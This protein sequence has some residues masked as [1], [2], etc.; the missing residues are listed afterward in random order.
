MNKVRITSGIYFTFCL[1]IIGVISCTKEPFGKREKQGELVLPATSYAYFDKHGINN[2]LATLGRVLFYD[3]QLSANNAVS[4]GSCHKQE[5]AFANNVRFDKG[6]NG[7]ELNRN[8]P[9]IQGINGFFSNS[10]DSSAGMPTLQNQNQVLLFWD[11]RQNNVAD[12]VLNPV[13]NHNEM[14]LPDFE[15]LVKKLS[16][17]SYYP[18]LFQKSFG[19][20]KIT[21]ERIAFALEGFI[22]CMNSNGNSNGNDSLNE[23]EEQGKLLFHNKYNCAQCHDRSGSKFGSNPG[24]YGGGS[25]PSEMFNIGLDEVYKDNGLGK[26]TGKPGDKGLFKVPTL[27]N[28]SVTAPYMHDGRFANLGEVLD[29]YSHGIKNNIN[30]S[31]KFLNTD[32]TPTKLNITPVEK[33]AIIAFLNTL[34]NEDFLVNP[35]YANPFKKK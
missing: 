34:K 16:E 10:F 35:M 28:I 11:G 9:S 3:Q 29:H 7:L 26:I 21:K 22:S 23:L 14:N 1:I 12:M 25:D 5:F 6:F 24:G 17:V 2:N 30:L 33:K 32:G 13:L 18:L 19:D 8:S 4:C 20:Q 27:Q 15:T 31:S